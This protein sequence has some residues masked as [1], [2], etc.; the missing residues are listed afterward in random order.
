MS[1]IRDRARALLDHELPIGVE[2]KSNGPENGKRYKELTGTDPQTLMDN[3][4]TGGIMTACNGFVGWYAGQL[5]IKG[6][7]SWFDLQKSLVSAKKPNAWVPSTAKVR[8]KY[9]DILRHTTFHV[10]V[11]LDFDGDVL[12][13][14]A[15]GQSS[16]PRPTADVSQEYD[17]VLRVRG[18]G[19]YNFQNLQGW[20][21][22][23]L[24]FASPLPVPDWLVG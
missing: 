6:I 17:N 3:W 2:Y 22:L 13:R 9:G 11:A 12:L 4:K 14:A 15:A 7:A 20:L 1:D 24:F 21:D 8:P 23:D 18:K 19:P 16:H 5:G 10:D